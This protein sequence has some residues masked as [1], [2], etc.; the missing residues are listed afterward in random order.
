MIY[1]VGSDRIPFQVSKT[2]QESPYDIPRDQHERTLYD[3]PKSLS[4]STANSTAGSA[5]ASHSVIEIST[6][7]FDGIQMSPSSLNTAPVKL[8]D[9]NVYE[10]PIDSS[11]QPQVKA[12]LGG[13]VNDPQYIYMSNN[14]GTTDGNEEEAS[15]DDHRASSEVRR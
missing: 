11:W 8:Q 6:P 2:K 15:K 14:S 10:Q 9:G 7:P 12:A 3:I 1:R 5:V 4:N 13:I